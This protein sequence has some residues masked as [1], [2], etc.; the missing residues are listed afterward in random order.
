MKMKRINNNLIAIT[1]ML[2]SLAGC[3]GAGS[4]A[5]PTGAPSAPALTRSVTTEHYLRAKKVAT[6]ITPAENEYTDQ[7]MVLEIKDYNGI[8]LSKNRSECAS[9]VTLLLKHSYSLTDTD[10]TTKFG[11]TSPWAYQY[12]DKIA[13]S[14]ALGQPLVTGQ[15]F[16]RI[17]KVTDLEEGDLLALKY[18]DSTSSN[19]GHVMVVAGKPQYIGTDNLDST[20]TQVYDIAIIDST[21]SPHGDT[22]KR[23]TNND[24]GVG[25]GT[26]RVYVDPTTKEVVAHKWSPK[27][28]DTTYRYYQ[29][30]AKNGETRHLELGRFLTP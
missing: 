14:P 3:A 22:D 28:N 27:A 10:F 1:L 20:S 25:E 18:T 30:T 2:G 13:A 6:T 15:V 23:K 19:T 26:F 8:T 7:N 21:K 12:H 16:S 29:S 5:T 9:F 4:Y 11:S 24:T 17:S